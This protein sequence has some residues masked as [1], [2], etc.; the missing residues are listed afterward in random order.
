[1]T[2]KLNPHQPF[3]WRTPFD[4]QVGVGKKQVR[5]N[6]VSAG[7]ERFIDAL[8]LGIAPNQVEAVA[9]QSKLAVEQAKKLIEQLEPLM[10]RRIAEPGQV[11]LLDVDRAMA[12]I[13]RASLNHASDGEL[14]LTERSKRTVFIEKLD[15]TGLLLLNALA[16]AGVGRVIT[17][18]NS[19]VLNRDI[20]SSGYPIA[21][22]GKKRIVAAQMMLN[23][24]H[25]TITLVPP[26]RL[27]QKTL[28]QTD[29]AFFT[30]QQT[31]QAAQYERWFDFKAAQLAV[32]F[33]SDGAWISGVM[34][35]GDTPCLECFEI[36]AKLADSSWP[37]L[38][39]QLITSGLRFDDES[40]R[41]LA[42]GLAVQEILAEL[43]AIASFGNRSS[44]RGFMVDREA[45]H[46][47]E[48]S[49]AR[50]PQCRCGQLQSKADLAKQVA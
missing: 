46:V 36:S 16:A 8:Y 44:H 41:L 23:A 49:W 30:T 31:F 48:V 15:A 17:T 42:V 5:I 39:L 45:G 10:L 3:L 11:N 14:V 22:L 6:Q 43:D 19:A 20:G 4:A 1:M 9:K 25:S 29:L 18:D 37:V 13:V 28:S 38:G 21:F 35:I 50:Q 26:G 32:N 2:V 40:T 33:N 12:E 47:D 24:S 7:H 27:R 34:R